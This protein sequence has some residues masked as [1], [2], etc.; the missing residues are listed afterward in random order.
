[1]ATTTI[2]ASSKLKALR[3]QMEANDTLVSMDDFNS[4][5]IVNA[6]DSMFDKGTV[7]LVPSNI[8]EIPRGMEKIK[9][10]GRDPI[11]C[12]YIWLDTE[13]HGIKK[14]FLSQLSKTVVPYKLND[15]GE[16]EVDDDAEIIHATDEKATDLFNKLADCKTAGAIIELIAGNKIEVYDTKTCKGPKYV[17]G[18]MIGIRDVTVPLM[19]WKR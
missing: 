5:A 7:F 16:P 4:H 8:D 15:E 6:R 18:V 1:M 12:P 10:A 9:I 3:D 11:L 19:N 14:L 13:H 2:T 17:N